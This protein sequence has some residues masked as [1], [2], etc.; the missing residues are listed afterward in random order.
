MTSSYL[1]A[2]G[3][4]KCLHQVHPLFGADRA[5]DGGVSQA[6]PLQVQGYHVQHAGPLGDDDAGSKQRTKHQPQA[7]RKQI[8]LQGLHVPVTRKSQSSNV[9]EE[10]PFAPWGAKAHAQVTS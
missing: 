9:D 7:E 8:H 5:I 1:R 4:V 10:R 6:V 3:A 2:P